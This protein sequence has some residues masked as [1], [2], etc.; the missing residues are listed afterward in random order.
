MFYA[1]HGG[2]KEIVKRMLRLGAND[3][4]YEML[5]AAKC[6]TYQKLHQEIA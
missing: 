2:H 3:Y 1:T 6:K 4:N 5:V